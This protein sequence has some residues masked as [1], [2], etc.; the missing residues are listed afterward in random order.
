MS[1]NVAQHD[2]QN[3]KELLSNSQDDMQKAWIDYNQ[4]KK[5]I[6]VVQEKAKKEAINKMSEILSQKTEEET[7][8]RL[9]K[10]C[11]LLIC[12]VRTLFNDVYG[13]SEEELTG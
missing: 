4:L 8:K 3:R 6:E 13:K 5:E 11:D 2:I 1:N 7:L 10:I 9:E 12:S